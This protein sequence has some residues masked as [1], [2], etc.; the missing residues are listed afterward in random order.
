VSET[1]DLK[2]KPATLGNLIALAACGDW[3][4]P[5]VAMAKDVLR[6]GFSYAI[7]R[8]ESAEEFAKKWAGKLGPIDPSD[9]DSD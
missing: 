6:N 9:P 8:R 5:D 2:N 7:A 4:D 3:F 1:E